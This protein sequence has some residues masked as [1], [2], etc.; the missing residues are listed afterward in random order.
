[1][2]SPRDLLLTLFDEKFT[3]R[4]VIPHDVQYLGMTAQDLCR[5]NQC[6]IVHFMFHDRVSFGG[7]LIAVGSQLLVH[8]NTPVGWLA[9]FTS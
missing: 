7:S 4:V 6:R 3:G 1:M 9:E 8:S 5:L 2:N